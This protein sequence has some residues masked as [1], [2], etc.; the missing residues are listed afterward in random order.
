VE[1]V[2]TKR[3]VVV[4]EGMLELAARADS[5]WTLGHGGDTLNTAIH[6]ARLGC[7]VALASA[8][9][10]DLFSTRLRSA[11]EL[12]GLDCSL[13]LTDPHRGPGLYAISLDDVGE[14][15]FAYWRSESAARQ[16]FAL[17]AS[18]AM[19]ERAARSNLL[20]FSLISLAIL[21]P[22]GREALLALARRVHQRAG[23]V[24]FDG[25]YRAILWKSREEAIAA[26]GAAISVAQIGLPTL[27]DEA[28]LSG[29]TNAEEVSAHWRGLGCKEVVVKLGP[30]GCLLPD[31]TIV[32][33]EASLSP[34]DTSGAGDAFNAGYL[35]ARLAGADPADAAK[36]GHRLSAWVIMRPGAIPARD[37][38]A[39][40]T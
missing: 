23:T 3:A 1:L 15:S 20:V 22:E 31:G 21:P 39:P 9:G 13:I 5:A 19:L 2:S 27:D 34:L 38:D 33:P 11:W 12:E 28:A 8:L 36:Q 10:S 6:M 35:A 14:R 18:E 24:A 16:M 4:G 7:G 40:Y 32:A 37:A 25:N 26:R 29:A 30:A 17:P